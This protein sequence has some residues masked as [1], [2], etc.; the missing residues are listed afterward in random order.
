MLARLSTSV[1]LEEL[2][3][4]KIES[5]GGNESNAPVSNFSFEL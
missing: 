1:W 5:T 4:A 3:K 2:Q